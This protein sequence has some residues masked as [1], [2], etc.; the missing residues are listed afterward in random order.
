MK[1]SFEMTLAKALPDHLYRA[2]VA[3]GGTRRFPA[4][5]VLVSEDDRSDTLYIIISGRIKAYGAAPDGREVV[6]GTQGPGE[7][8]GEI[9]LDGGPR[10]ASVM[11]LE[12][13]T[14]LVL[15]G[16]QINA[17][18]VEYP[19]FASYLVHKLIG[20][21][22]SATTN[23]KSLALGDVY[24]RLTGL[25][26]S[27]DCIEVDGRRVVTERLTQ[28]GIADRIGCSREMVSRILKQLSEDGYLAMTDHRIVLLRK[29]PTE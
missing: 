12:P 6:Y 5:A 26:E 27:M 14:C 21:V 15:S 23:V 25:L 8:F 24:H 3:R 13:T 10:S 28:Q 2:L 1:R 9:S 20:M 29:L 17:L 18:M 22:R 19:E 7:I 16:A 11:T 4:R